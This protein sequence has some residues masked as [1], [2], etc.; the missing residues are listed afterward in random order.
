MHNNNVA[1]REWKEKEIPFIFK[2]KYDKMALQK[3]I[4]VELP[5]MPARKKARITG[6]GSYLPE[7]V[8]SNA[9]F[10]KMVDTT[11]EW[12][13][14][15]TGMKERRI[16]AEDECTS[17]L[18]AKAAK[19]ALKDAG[20][21][22]SDI[23]FILVTTT[24]PDYLTPSTAALIQAKLGNKNAAAVD[25]EAACTGFLYALSMAKAYIESGMY[26]NILLVAAEK[27]SA[28]VDYEDRSTCVLFGDGASAAVVRDEGKGFY[29]DTVSLGA[30]GTLAELIM[31]PAGGARHPATA[32]TVEERQHSFKMSG[33]EV[34]K[35]AVRKMGAAAQGCLEQAK[36]VEDDISWIVPHQAN[37][38]IIDAIATKFHLSNDRVYKTVHKY[39][40]TSASS[41]G[42][43]LDELTRENSLKRGEHILLLAFGAGLTWG[44][45]IITKM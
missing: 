39:G 31:I 36:L 16:A 13:M 40:N 28:F 4:Y 30:D 14:S 27:M 33:R 17:D 32:K 8:L 12:I 37:E 15:R 2:S 1:K 3:R 42:I 25:T 43:A 6:L 20:L 11:D 29:I 19:L 7:R 44:A 24:T 45:S 10:E 26:K 9:D 34:F 22:A 21:K 41:I 35:H 23:D 5:R 18:G 38:R